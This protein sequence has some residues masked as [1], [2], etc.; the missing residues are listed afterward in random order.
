MDI[1]VHPSLSSETYTLHQFIQDHPCRLSFPSPDMTLNTPVTEYGALISTNKEFV[2]CGD[3]VRIC[4]GV[5]NGY[6][7]YLLLF[8]LFLFSQFDIQIGVL[9]SCFGINNPPQNFCMLQKL[10]PVISLLDQPSTNEFDCPLLNLTNDLHI[11]SVS[12]V[13]KPVS[14]VHC[15]TDSCNF[16][17][18]VASI[19]IEREYIA[20]SKL[21]FVHDP[22]NYLFCYNIFCTS[23]SS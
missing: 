2:N 14:V 9:L 13:V 22:H 11:L 16:M 15:C 6:N 19:N 8:M 5:S 1:S 23:N 4:D 18:S 21:V 12:F 10:V 7:I 17:D 20:S 3:Y